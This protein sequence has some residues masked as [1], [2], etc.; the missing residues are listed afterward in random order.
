MD[1]NPTNIVPSDWR[2]GDYYMTSL[3]TYDYWAIE[4][5]YKPFLGGT[6]GEVAE[7]KLIAARSGEP[8]LEFATDEDVLFA[9][10]DPDTNLFDMGDNTV[11]YARMQAQLVREA[12]P[13]LV[14][15]MTKEGDDYSQTRQAFN[16]LLARYGQSMYY[17]SRMIGGIRTNRSHRGDKDAR[18]PLERVDVNRQREAL[19]LLEEAMFRA[20]AFQFPSELYSYLVPSR[21]THW[22]TSFPGRR[23]F[24]I[25]DYIL[26]WQQ[27]VLN[28]LLSPSTLCRMHDMEL[29]AP[30]EEDVLTTAELMERLTKAI[31]AEVDVVSSG[32]YSMRRP[33]INSLR[34]NLQRALLEDLT[35]IAM[36]DAGVPADCQT[37]AYAELS[38][39]GDRLDKTIAADMNLDRYTRAHLIETRQRIRK[40][41]EAEYTLQGP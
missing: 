22:G 32:D 2:Q 35:R 6:Q 29:T 1:Y 8:G 11:A 37:V 15:R 13:G 16:V 40:A 36:G 25:H 38:D 3:G 26:M 27:E 28:Y 30:A 10:S 14:E 21:W 19:T 17:A 41:L 4:Y 34:R 9:N 31:F 12:V 18:P 24:P 33:A 5:G 39:L 20:D 7:L 23:D